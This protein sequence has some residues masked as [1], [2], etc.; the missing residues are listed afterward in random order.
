MKT[1]ISLPDRLF[2][3]ADSLAR[4]LGMS[5]SQLYATAVAEYVAKHQAAK[6]TERLNT[7]YRAEP[8]TLADDLRR[9]QRR[10]LERTDW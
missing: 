4:K 10:T 1:D 5:R 9:G 2:G 6:V 7:I 3:A 8:G